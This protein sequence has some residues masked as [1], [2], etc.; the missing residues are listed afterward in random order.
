MQCPLITTALSMV[1]T[2]APL[3]CA[4]CAF[5]LPHCGCV[6]VADIKSGQAMYFSPASSAFYASN[7]DSNN[8]GA[9]NTTYGLSAFPCRD[10][11]V[12]MVANTVY[13]SSAAYFRV[14]N[15][16]SPPRGGF[17]SPMACVTRPGFGFNGR[18]AS[19]CPVGTYN[20]PGTLTSCAKC[21]YGLSTRD[22][23]ESQVS[24]GNCTLAAG[25]GFHSNSVVPC[26]IGEP[27]GQS[28]TGLGVLSQFAC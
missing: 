9:P 11:S 1:V 17:I 15:N 12:G 25:F 14:D 20:P 10:C 21:P 8:Y 13:A 6:A 18:T 26:P 7:C 4:H 19:K 3:S 28:S 27:H 24:A 16:T 2:G 5:T 22:D 23:P